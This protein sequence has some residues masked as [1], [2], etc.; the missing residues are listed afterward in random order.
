[1]Y[2]ALGKGDQKI[3]V[4]PS[5]GWVVIRQGESANS[6]L[7][8]IEFDNK[9]WAQ[10]NALDCTSATQEALTPKI[11]LIVSPTITKNNWLVQSNEPFVT[12]TLYNTQ[13]ERVFFQHFSQNTTEFSCI[14][15]ELPAG[16]YHLMVTN[17][18]GTQ[19]W[20]KMIKI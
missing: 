20:A 11:N 18:S 1:M 16:I 9:L 3:H 2:A 19:G 8:P 10:L 17:Q 6:G 5:K 14:A 15:T 7:V 13:G 12:A 4:V